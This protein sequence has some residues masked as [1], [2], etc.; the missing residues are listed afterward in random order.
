MAEQTTQTTPAMYA[1]EVQNISPNATEK[2]VSDF[3]SFCGKISNL[4][5]DKDVSKGTFRAVVQFET[6]AAARTALLLTNALIV[7]RPITVLSYTKGPITENKLPQT[8]GTPV[9]SEHITHRDF[10]GVHDNERTK[11]SVLASMVAAGYVL[12]SDSLTKAK[13]YDEEH[14]QFSTKLKQGVEV[15]QNKA[16]ELDK[17]YGISDKV[18]AVKQSATEKAKKLDEDYHLSEKASAAVQSVKQTAQSVSDKAQE[19][20]T[21]KSGVDSVKAGMATAVQYYKD[22]QAQTSKAIEEKQKAR[23]STEIQPGSVENVDVGSPIVLETNVNNNN[24]EAK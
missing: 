19:N 22:L 6:E 11:T 17:Q 15:V 23:S 3:F 2:T 16:S 12:A 9:S 21:I 4:Y 24:V 7:D 14:T 8:P 20:P 5:M 13:S 18:G 1:V 10:G